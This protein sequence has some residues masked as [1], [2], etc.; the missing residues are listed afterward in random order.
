[1]NGNTPTLISGVPNVAFSDATIRSQASAS[2]SAPGEAV[3][4]RRAQH[5][6]AQLADQR[7]Q[8]REALGGE[9]LVHERDVGREAAEVAAAR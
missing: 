1:M 6:L 8:P 4:V 9:M 7:E 3:A 5:R 2:P